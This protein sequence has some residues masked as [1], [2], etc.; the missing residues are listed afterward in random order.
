MTM[1]G[2]M[3]I[4]AAGHRGDDHD[5][6]RRQADRPHG[7]GRIVLPG[8]LLIIASF[9]SLTQVTATTSYWWLGVVLFV[10]GLGM[11]ELRPCP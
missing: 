7:V 4:L 5:A 6:D 8:M 11:G 9:V 1:P 2:G 10:M 3:T